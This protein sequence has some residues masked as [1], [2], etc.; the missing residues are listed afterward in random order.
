[1]S[2]TYF[3]M[4][5]T[6]S[7]ITAEN[8]REVSCPTGGYFDKNLRRRFESKRQKRAF[9]AAH[10]MREAGELYNPNKALGG[11]EGRVVKQPKPR[12][13]FRASPMPAWMKQELSHVR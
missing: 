13:N 3:F 6:P 12:G 4:D 11:S 9:L 1:M 8:K 5:S 7:T 10:G 2:K